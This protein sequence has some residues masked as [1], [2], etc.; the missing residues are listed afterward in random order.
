MSSWRVRDE[1]PGDAA[2]L[3]ALTEAAF[4]EAAH[5]DGS[6]GAIAERLR[7]SG[8]L[9]VSLVAEADAGLVGHVAF[10]P[11]AIS[12]GAQDWYGLGPVAVVPERQGEGI[13]AALIREGIARLGG[14]RAGGCVVLGAPDYY[15]RFGFG[16]DPALVFPGP[17]AEY[18]L[19]L[20]LAGSAPAGDVRYAP[21]F[22]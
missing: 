17:P 13:G 8:D 12:D 6:E 7:R 18:F 3:A 15:A 20:V 9:A 10:S 19:R 4:R 2:A 14:L 16:H 1:R 22:S 11:V 5:R 21:A